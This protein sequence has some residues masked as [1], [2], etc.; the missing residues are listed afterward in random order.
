[1]IPITLWIVEDDAGYR[2]MLQQI[3]NWTDH[4]TCE[5]IFPS[6]IEFFD[7]LKS[8]KH[9]DM[10][11][12]DLGLPEMGGVEGIKKLAQVAPDITVM[13]LSVFQDKENVLQALE[14]GASGYLLKTASDEDIVKGINDIFMGKASLS[15]AVAKI[16]LDSMQQPVP[17]KQFDLSEREIQVL[18]KLADGLA[19]KEIAGLLGISTPTVNFHLKNIYKKL[20]VPSQ[21][22]AVAKALRS[23]II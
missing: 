20:D 15:P 4:I 5:E 1:M 12:M 7:A 11:L 8:E 9:P 23:N 18:E 13:V 17:E 19:S 2:R 16:V 3:L 21:S 14:A 22:G 6:C 10:V